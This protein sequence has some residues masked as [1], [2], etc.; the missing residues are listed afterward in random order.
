MF[1]IKKI[2]TKRIKTN[3]SIN[4]IKETLPGLKIKVIY[5]AKRVLNIFITK[6]KESQEYPN[7]N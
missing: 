5:Q 2:T 3:L 4:F 7:Q 6:A 1:S